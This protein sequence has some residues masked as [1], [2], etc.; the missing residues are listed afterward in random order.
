M[1]ITNAENS[2]DDIFDIAGDEFGEQLIAAEDI[3]NFID[4]RLDVDSVLIDDIKLEHETSANVYNE[5]SCDFNI[6]EI[7]EENVKGWLFISTLTPQ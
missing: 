4:S 7:K 6:S 2:F 5:Q 1:I 3:E